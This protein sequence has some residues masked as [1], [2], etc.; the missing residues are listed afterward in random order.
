MLASDFYDET[1]CPLSGLQSYAY[2]VGTAP[3]SL[4]FLLMS[5]GNGLNKVG[6][7]GCVSIRVV[8]FVRYQGLW[9]LFLIIRV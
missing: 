2:C 7:V 6:R 5:G 9:H 1:I 4:L 3:R 8:Y